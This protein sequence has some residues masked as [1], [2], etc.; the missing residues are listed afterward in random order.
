MSYTSSTFYNLKDA[1]VISE[2]QI[3]KRLGF[4]VQVQL[5][6]ASMVSYCQMLGMVE[7]E[8]V[9]DKAWGFLNDRFVSCPLSSSPHSPFVPFRLAD[10]LPSPYPNCYFLP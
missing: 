4:N 6:Y 8:G 2:M 3:L 10:L 5:P 9:V 1:I 7:K